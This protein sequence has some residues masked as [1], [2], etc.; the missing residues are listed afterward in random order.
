MSQDP[1]FTQIFK[2]GSTT[3]FYS[4]LFFPEAIRTDVFT[5]YAYV[6][7]ADNFVDAVPQQAEEFA[8]FEQDTHDA[9][10]GKRVK[11]DI[12][13]AF[14]QLMKRKQ[15]DP[16]WVLS[17]LNAMKQDLTKT[18]YHTFHALEEY[19]YGSANVI[20]LM[21]ARICDL[22]EESFRYAQMQG[23]AMQLINF[24][25]DVK[26]DSQLGRTYL[27]VEDMKRFGIESLHHPKTPAEIETFAAFMV[28]QIERYEQIQK[29]AEEG[30]PFIPRQLRI[31]I[32]TAAQ[33]YLWTAQQIKNN[34]MIVF[35]KKV[36][37]HPAYVVMEYGKN[38]ITG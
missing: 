20:G 25:R 38:L 19:M 15:F 36:K 10:A 13:N 11:N 27:P 32:K 9:L 2:K 34:P 37:P 30:Y 8:V 6:R 1:S 17:F 31:P 22:P 5:L 26:E 14:V 4:S 7:T 35:E 12:V 33:I 23:K 21:M 29:E 18:T 28:Y 24:V 16:E 3:Y